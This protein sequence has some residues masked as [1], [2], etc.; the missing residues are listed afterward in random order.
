MR[1]A[2]RT[3]MVDSDIAIRSA[4]VRDY[5]RCLPLFSTLYHGDIGVGFRKTFE[6]FV[7]SRNGT[8]LIACTRDEIVGVL[9]GSNA[10][11]IDWEGMTARIDAVVVSERKRRMGIGEHLVGHFVTLAKRRGCKAVKSRIG[12]KNEVSRRFHESLGFLEAKTYEYVL[13]LQG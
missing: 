11:D 6:S 9:A 12:R 10:I 3:D 2:K 13:D 5:D 4:K 1:L 8:V 7:R